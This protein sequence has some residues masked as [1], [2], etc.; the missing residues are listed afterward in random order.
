MSA[1]RGTTRP[2]ARLDADPAGEPTA[3]ADCLRRAALLELL[4]PR[5]EYVGRD[6]DR[7]AGL[8]DL[9]DDELLQGV[10]G[11]AA[12][13]LRERLDAA[14]HDQPP[15]VGVQRIC[16]HDERYPAALLEGPAAPRM[17]H[18][19]GGIERLGRLLGEPA[20]AV[21]GSRAPSDYGL[22]V[23][24]GL[25]R[26][27]AASGVTVIS[28]LADGI[29]A[30]AH[31]GAL[32][33]GG[34]TLTVMAGGVDVCRPASRRQLHRRLLQTG[35]AI[36]ELP[37][38]NGP[39]GWYGAARARIVVALAKLVVVVEGTDDPGDLHARI[40]R[41]RGRLIG[42]VPGRVT[43]PLAAGPHRLL[44]E[45]ALVVRGAQDALDALYGVGGRE[46]VVAAGEEEGRRRLGPELRAV[47]DRVG[48]GEDSI[49]KLLAGGGG[50]QVLEVALAKLEL[51]GYL[52][53]GDGG[54]YLPLV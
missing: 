15:P 4:S 30:A 49:G 27:L 23:A 6:P 44:R 22:E 35:C 36:A 39:G 25:G 1:A 45:G 38:G 10:A 41:G 37:C 18:L 2:E 52:V 42:A 50:R 26:D 47:L 31:E 46:V 43:S 12:R 20:V 8:F 24:H 21:V 29:A 48:A 40:A 33:A 7:L 54:R 53:R 28:G 5:L 19:A 11:D 14:D 32:D 9:S 34:P 17:L 16:R 51:G 3:C 13:G